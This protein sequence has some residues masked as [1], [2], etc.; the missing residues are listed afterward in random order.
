M[1]NDIN[2][3]DSLKNLNRID[4]VI[5]SSCGKRCF[6]N[7]K[8][9]KLN[10]AENACITTCVQKYYDALVIGDKVFDH[11]SKEGNFAQLQKG[12]YDEIFG[13]LKTTFDI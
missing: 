2:T 10:S 6:A 8:S 12:N 11:F 4:S 5:I 13:N 7:L 3:I 1:S 9:E